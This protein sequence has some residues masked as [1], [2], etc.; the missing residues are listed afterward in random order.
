MLLSRHME[1]S[2]MNE[3]CEMCNNKI[4]EEGSRVIFADK[5]YFCVSCAPI[6]P[7]EQKTPEWRGNLARPRRANVS[8]S[9]HYAAWLQKKTL[10]S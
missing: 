7:E 6:R 4:G 3:Y 8:D 9:E 10:F 2:A 1:N 5:M